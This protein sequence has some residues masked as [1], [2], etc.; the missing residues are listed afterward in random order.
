MAQTQINKHAG[1]YIRVSTEHQVD[2]NSLKT[3]EERL[4]SFC[5]Q[6]GYKIFK[7][8][9]DAG[10]SAK[11][12]NRPA[13]AELMQDIKA[14]NID[15]ILVTKLDRITRSIRD[16]FKLMDFFNNNGVHFTSL[17]ESIDTKTAMGRFFYQLLGLLAQ[18]ERE[19]TAERVATDMRH[20]AE[21]GKW[22][23]GVVPFGYIT[24]AVA[25]KKYQDLGLNENESL[26]KALQDCPERKKLY[27]DPDTSKIVKW[28]FDKYIEV[29]SVRKVCTL[30]NSSGIKTAK[31]E[32]WSQTTI[33]RMLGTPIYIGKTYYGKRKTDPFNGKLVPQD[34]STWTVVDAEHEAI[35]SEAT[36][37]KVQEMLSMNSKKPTKLGRVYLLTG[38]IKC[39]LCGRSM[40]GYTFT[41]KG[42]EKSYSYYK[43]W[44]RLQK[45][46]VACKGITIPADT[47]DNFIINQLLKLSENHTFLSD[48]KKI[49]ETMKA[50]MKGPAIDNELEEYNIKIKD[51]R[52]KLSLLLDKLQDGLIQDEDFKPRYNK[53]KFD[54]KVME[55]EKLRL[56]G[57]GNNQQ[58]VME[59]LNASF[60]EIT[61][62]GANWDLLDEIG[63]AMR[64][65]SI[66]KEIRVTKENI[67]LDLFLDVVNVS[68][69]DRGSSR[70]P[71]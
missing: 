36:Y 39:G 68:H 32:L 45:G 69:K 44:S 49:I 26:S 29:N 5:Q 31:G 56:I 8:Y 1:L 4:I 57:L 71:A 48:K 65:K 37:N 51:L 61:S 3:Q 19:V 24:Q 40:S 22:T 42:T 41:K 18:L 28:I 43:C 21:R 17:S 62:F 52:G 63:K 11:D 27:S 33:H 15:I 10:L 66:V 67:E 20:R 59:N 35:V 12:T 23:G 2:K 6:M 53:I 7:V 25:I 64:I 60:E 47:L 70:L 34:E 58:V 14:G 9:K 50:N 46:M 13:L 16:L 55:D 38:M 54:L 30:L